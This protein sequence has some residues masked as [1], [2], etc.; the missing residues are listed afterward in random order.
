VVPTQKAPRLSPGGNLSAGYGIFLKHV[1]LGLALLFSLGL[2]SYGAGADRY[3]IGLT[4]VFLDNQSS[5]LNVWRAYL[6]SKLGVPV[7]FV[8]RQRYGEITELLLLNQLDIAWVCGFPYI[9]HLNRSQL[10]AMPLYRGE[11]LY[12]SYLIVPAADEATRDI[13]DLEGAVFAYSDPDSNSGYL[14][15]RVQLHK[16]KKDPSDFFGKTFYTWNHRDVVVAVADGI[17]QGGAVDGYVWETLAMTRP[18][19]TERTRVVWKSEWYGFPPFVARAFL[20]EK[21]FLRFQRVLLEMSDDPE[22]RSLLEV[23]N[24]DGFV[25]GNDRL[26]DGIRNAVRTL[27][28]G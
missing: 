8:Q 13:R 17:A 23:L 19:L 10:L 5:F 18:G 9:R 12:Q 14:V 1:L 25:P 2:P 28:Q 24:L 16:A 15:P 6:E 27:E 3:R 22:G 4:P 21:D 20:P 7:E 11:P 26:F